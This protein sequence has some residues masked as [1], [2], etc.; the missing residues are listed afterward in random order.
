M[1]KKSEKNGGNEKN[2]KNTAK[3][4]YKWVKYA[5]KFLIPLFTVFFYTLIIAAIVLVLCAIILLF[6]NVP[7]EK[8]I[9]PPFMQAVKDGSKLLGYDVYLGNGLK[10]FTGTEFL[11]LSNIKTVYYI[12][13]AGICTI[14]L[15]AAPT[16]KFL[17]LLLCN[18]SVD[19]F[20]NAKN[21]QYI[22]FIGRAILAGG[23]IVSIIRY[24]FNYY[25]VKLFAEDGSNVSFSFGINLFIVAL[26]LLVIFFGHIYGYVCSMNKLQAVSDNVNR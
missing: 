17:A 11:R 3:I 18:I 8:M 21:P 14:L 2:A 10:I 5:A 26:G 23:T 22:D 4:K 15:T 24:F 25:L 6:I 13:I 1:L 16:V 12:T 7:V 9:M 20:F 19:D